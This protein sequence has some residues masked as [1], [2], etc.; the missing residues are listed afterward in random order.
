MKEKDYY[1]KKVESSSNVQTT[2]DTRIASNVIFAVASFIL[3]GVAFGIGDQIFGSTAMQ[4]LVAFGCVGV[5][6]A[7]IRA[8]REKLKVKSGQSEASQEKPKQYS[9]GNK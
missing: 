1:V 4:Y 2:Q 3:A 8:M 6:N 5:T 9:K 7:N